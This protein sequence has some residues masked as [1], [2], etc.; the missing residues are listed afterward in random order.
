MIGAV[1]ERRSAV[2]TMDVKEGEF[3]TRCSPLSDKE[4]VLGVAVPVIC[5]NDLRAVM[6]FYGSRKFPDPNSL[7]RFFDLLGVHVSNIMMRLESLN[8]EKEHL[9]SLVN[10]SK[11]ATLGEITAGVAHEIN[12][13]LHTLSLSAQVV[14]KMSSRGLLTEGALRE[15][16]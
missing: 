16:C 12:N 4:H 2:L 3:L 7:R 11:M 1:L 6:E 14:K 10:A 15:L 13:P 5:N 9:A 8:R